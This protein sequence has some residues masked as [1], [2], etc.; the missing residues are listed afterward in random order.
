MWDTDIPD[1]LLAKW[2]I[3]KVRGIPAEEW[4][5]DADSPWIK[6]IEWMAEFDPSI[7]NEGWWKKVMET[8]IVS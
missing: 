7:Q 3:R 4:P 6:N 1:C 2:A 5:I 8:S